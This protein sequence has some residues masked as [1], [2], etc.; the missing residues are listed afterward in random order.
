M[1]YTLD[2]KVGDILD[3]TNAVKS[4]KNT[5]RAFPRIPCS[6]WQAE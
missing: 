6:H 1:P 4:W 3:D 5:L 2:T